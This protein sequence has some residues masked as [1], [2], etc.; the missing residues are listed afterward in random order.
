[1]KK[2]TRFTIELNTFLRKGLEEIS[3]KYGMSK[4]DIVRRGIVEQLEKLNR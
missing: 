2:T 1:M 3:D 4:A